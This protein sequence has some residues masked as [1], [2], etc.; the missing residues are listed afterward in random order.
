[1]HIHLASP[2]RSYAAE[3]AIVEHE[4]RSVAELLDTM[5]AS[6]PGIRF[7]MIDEQDAIRR[8]I[9]IFVNGALIDNLTRPLHPSD[10]V[11]ILCAISGG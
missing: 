10:T 4:A 7:R 11:H 5:D 2:L 6:Y 1:M 9:R 3:K 8:H